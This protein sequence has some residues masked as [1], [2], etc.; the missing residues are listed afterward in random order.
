MKRCYEGIVEVED[1]DPVARNEL[2]LFVEVSG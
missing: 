2:W 1:A